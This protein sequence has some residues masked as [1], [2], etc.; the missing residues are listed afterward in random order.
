MSGVTLVAPCDGWVTPLSEIDDPVFAEGMMGE[1][2]AIDPLGAEITAPCDGEVILIHR[3]RHAVTLRA[4]CGAEILI[5]IGLETVSLQG[6][7]FVCHVRAGE[8]VVS[9]ARLVSFD[10]DRVAAAAKSLI[11]PIILTNGG[12]FQL[13]PPHSSRRIRRGE[14]LFTLRARPGQTRPR[15]MSDEVAERAMI[16][17]LPHGIHAR[18]AARLAELARGFECAITVQFAERTVPIDRPVAVMGLG[19]GH[20]ASILLRASGRGAAAALDRL[21]A[22]IASGMGEQ[23][24]TAAPAPLR[25]ASAVGQIGAVRAAPGFRLGN[26]FRLKLADIAISETSEDPARESEKL[27]T[28]L[29]Q[30]VQTLDQAG[31]AIFAAHRA[32]LEDQGLH[33]AALA[34]IAAGASAG[35]G[36]RQA[37]RAQSAILAGLDDPRFR[38]RIADLEDIERR[39][40]LALGGEPSERIDVPD[41]AIL[42]ADDLLPSQLAGLDAT[43]LAGIATKAGGPTSHVAILA[44]MMGIPALVAC[45]DSLD[46]I[47][48]GQRLLIDADHGILM[49][50]L[51]AEL[52]AAAEAKLVEA[53]ARGRQIA[54][55]AL[56][57]CVMRDGQRIEIAANL[58]SVAD[59]EH[60]IRQGAEGCGLLRTE[61]LFLD[62]ASPPDEAEQIIAYRAIAGALQNR[63]LIIRTLDIGGDKPAA[64]LPIP[65]EE[66][67]ALGLRGVRV[68]LW[69][70]DL[71]RT[72]LRAILQAVPG[73]QC[74]IML[75]MIATLEELR[76]VRTMLDGLQQELMIPDRVA[77]GVM[78]ETPAAA[79]TADLLA[80]EAD[81]LSIGSNDLT[82]Y[83]LAMDRGNPQL[84]AQ[85]D[86][87]HPAVLRLIAAAAEGGAK[88]QRWTGVCG[89]LAS[90]LT[91]APILVGLGVRELS[92]TANLIPELKA[93][94]CELTLA[95]CQDLA[96]RALVAHSAAE[97]RALTLG[98]R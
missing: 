87:L 64:Y 41:G 24:E 33:E 69:R 37:I 81:F 35:K 3:A 55:A 22:L 92:A 8:R 9:G 38:E 86:G 88:R 16:V 83:C 58:G 11:T 20:G 71:L 76:R 1:G 7:G 29:R 50:S 49:T 67:P 56:E 73:R 60:A 91:A 13:E 45:G 40:L 94:L 82:Q 27:R 28:A 31:G 44:A 52:I 10:A 57:P 78:V 12:E 25:S 47:A 30:V 42:L 77:L 70:P 79:I 90:D 23:P 65:S 72:Q 98:G 21:E 62:R 93:L 59:A 85:L 18:P 32:F 39:V 97:V 96:S 63:P 2:I 46:A 80:I 95:Q 34:E 74:R 6:D 4:D 54:A 68:S 66:N 14:I 89:G 84:A 5:H 17:P 75:P 36:W 53:R 26:A 61:F 48:D 19:I 51:S 43:R 15:T